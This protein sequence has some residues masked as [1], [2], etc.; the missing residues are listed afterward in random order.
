[1][2]KQLY[3]AMTAPGTGWS[4]DVAASGQADWGAAPVVQNSTLPI[5]T[6]LTGVGLPFAL[7]LPVMFIENH[8][9]LKDGTTAVVEDTDYTID[10]DLGEVVILAGG[11]F[12]NGV[13]FGTGAFTISQGYDI[14]AGWFIL[15][16]A[17]VSTAE[18]I[19]VGIRF[20]ARQTVPDNPQATGIEFTCWNTALGVGESYDLSDTARRSDPTNAVQCLVAPNG[21]VQGGY[22]LTADRVLFH[23]LA[24]GF[25]A[26]ACVGAMARFRPLSEQSQIVGMLGSTSGASAGGL[27]D[28]PVGDTTEPGAVE[29]LAMGTVWDHTLSR[30]AVSGDAVQMNANVWSFEAQSAPS[31][32][33]VV[34]GSA[35]VM[36]TRYVEVHNVITA[37]NITVPN[38]PTNVFFGLWLGLFT[39]QAFEPRHNDQFTAIGKTFRLWRVG[40]SLQQ[41]YI[42]VEEI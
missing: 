12:D 35:Q 32:R 25:C 24:D 9:V 19:R 11:A 27:S 36:P 42:A 13:G 1:M 30:F 16:S 29:S 37:K 3:T 10:P 15:T 4:V 6:D 34:A 31:N 28:G 26:W 39:V 8:A 21:D 5:A 40:N 14:K 23:G 22:S 33:I 38:S 2:F 18:T 17:G 20:A 41:R 7:P